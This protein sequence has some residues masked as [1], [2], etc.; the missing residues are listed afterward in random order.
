MKIFSNSK[1]KTHMVKVVYLLESH[2]PSLIT[3]QSNDK[4]NAKRGTKRQSHYGNQ[5]IPCGTEVEQKHPVTSWQSY[6]LVEA[7]RS[8]RIG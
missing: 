8:I 4:E 6:R 2:M 1:G 3:V 7:D 5:N